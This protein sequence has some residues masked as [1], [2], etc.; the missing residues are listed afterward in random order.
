MLGLDQ[1]GKEND[2]DISFN[3]DQ[4]EKSGLEDKLIILDNSDIYN[5][6][7]KGQIFSSY[8]KLDLTNVAIDALSEGTP[9]L[10]FESA[11]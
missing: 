10:C 1:A 3:K 9:V 11:Y 2:Y 5:K 6:L 7:M 8:I 4:I